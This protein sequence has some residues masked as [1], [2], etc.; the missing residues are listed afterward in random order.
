MLD[1]SV[2]LDDFDKK[3]GRNKLSY[4]CHEQIRSILIG[5]EGFLAWTGDD[6]SRLLLKSWAQGLVR[7]DYEVESRKKAEIATGLWLTTY[8]NRFEFR[9]S[10]GLGE[11]L[12]AFLGLYGAAAMLPA[13][14]A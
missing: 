5:L 14:A 2:Y 10:P 3:Y 13:H 1:V 8:F 9:F 4:H 6:T 7:A 11:Q 12:T